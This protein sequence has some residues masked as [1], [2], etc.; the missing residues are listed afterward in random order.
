[1]KIAL[2]GLA[3]VIVGAW[4]SYSFEHRR[5]LRAERLRAWTEILTIVPVSWQR[6]HRAQGELAD[7]KEGRE[8][9]PS[10]EIMESLYRA[11]E[12]LAGALSAVRLLGP[13]EVIELVQRAPQ[14]KADVPV[15]LDE[16]EKLVTPWRIE[17]EAVARRHIKPRWS[18]WG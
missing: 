7:L 11:T 17:F 6:V 12:V 14:P 2:V 15:D 8:T 5:W 13:D 3:G 4:L 10:T 1:M 18:R 16:A 9:R